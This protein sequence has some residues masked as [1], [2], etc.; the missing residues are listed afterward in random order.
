[1]PDRKYPMY[2][3]HKITTVYKR[4]PTN[5]YKTLLDEFAHPEFDYLKSNNW[6]FTEKVDGTNIRVMYD[7][8]GI[9]FGGKTDK[10]QIP[11]FLESKLQEVFTLENVQN[12][13]DYDTGVCL[14]GEGFGARIQKGGGNYISDGVDFCLFDVKVGE[15][16]LERENVEDVAEKLGL[17]ITPII[18]QGNL[19]TAVEQTRN[20]FMSRW[21]D[22]Q[23]EGMV[24]RPEVELLNRRGNRIITKIKHKD[25]PK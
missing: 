8:E 14:Y 2:P 10:A 21:G 9:R 5:N 1:M 19:Y 25:F 3:Y 17:Q 23:A 13:F 24:M 20:G 22:F 7:A 16:F 6:V 18:G 12:A 4:D 11:P 15:M